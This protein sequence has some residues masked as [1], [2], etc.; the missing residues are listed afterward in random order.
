[1]PRDRHLSMGTKQTENY[2]Q[3]EP[4]LLLWRTCGRVMSF[5]DRDK[6]V[7]ELDTIMIGHVNKIKLPA[8][9]V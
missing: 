6:L 8:C 7:L 9:T 2:L 5:S 4:R 3:N 1:M